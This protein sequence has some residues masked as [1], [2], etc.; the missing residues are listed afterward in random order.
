MLAGRKRYVEQ[1]PQKQIKFQKTDWLAE[2][3]AIQKGVQIAHTFRVIFTGPCVHSTP[4]ESTDFFD[5]TPHKRQIKTINTYLLIS[6]QL[7]QVNTLPNIK[8]TRR[9]IHAHLN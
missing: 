8:F 3:K 6:I 4:A 2:L 7:F 1:S 5:E 9:A